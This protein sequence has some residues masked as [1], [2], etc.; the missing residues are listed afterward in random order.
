MFVKIINA[1]GV[2]DISE[3]LK[4][5]VRLAVASAKM[6][7]PVEEIIKKEEVPDNPIQP[8]IMIEN[9]GVLSDLL[10]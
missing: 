3:D 5:K 8:D 10:D 7:V 6:S 1:T 2:A 4:E 9:I